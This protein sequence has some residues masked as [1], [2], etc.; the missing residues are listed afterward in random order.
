MPN[1]YTPRTMTY[2]LATG[3]KLRLYAV[4]TL[5]DVWIS[6]D[7]HFALDQG[8]QKWAK[9]YKYKHGLFTRIRLSR[10]NGGVWNPTRLIL[11][12]Y[13]G[14]HSPLMRLLYHDG[15][16]ENKRFENINLVTP[17]DFIR[18]HINRDDRRM[19]EQDHLHKKIEDGKSEILALV[20]SGLTNIELSERYGCTAQAIGRAL[21]KWL[22]KR[23]LNSINK[24]K[25]INTRHTPAKVKKRIIEDLK[26]S[27]FSQREIAKRN[28]VNDYTV[29]RIKRGTDIPL[30]AKTK[31]LD[32]D[33]EAVLAQVARDGITQ[34][35]NEWGVKYATIWNIVNGKR[36]I[37]NNPTDNDR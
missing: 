20:K 26:A 34:T 8:N 18:Y 2:L 25:G 19:C 21:K 22:T 27:M 36:K 30:Q 35:A 16:P 5:F 12:A 10:L 1:S 15:N 29:C 37:K 23:K 9:P 14:V 11:L 13:T 32:T 24:R 31:I 33:F 17:S 3:E 7:G 6:E 28:G 4:P